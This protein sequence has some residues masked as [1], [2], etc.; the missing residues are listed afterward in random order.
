MSLEA[1]DGASLMQS[2]NRSEILTG[3]QDM[4]ALASLDRF[5]VPDPARST[6]FMLLDVL[7]P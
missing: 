5:P 3:R 7:G 1:V 6:R 4:P 2:A